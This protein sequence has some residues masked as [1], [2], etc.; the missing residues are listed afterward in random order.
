MFYTEAGTWVNQLQARE[1]ITELL[2]NHTACYFYI[3]ISCLSGN[4]IYPL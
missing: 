3:M 4:V 1:R 2:P